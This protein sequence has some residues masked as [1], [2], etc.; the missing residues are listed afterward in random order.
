MVSLF[1]LRL[2]Q[3]STAVAQQ[4]Q[5][6]MHDAVGCMQR[7]TPDMFSNTIRGANIRAAHLLL[8]SWITA[9][10]SCRGAQQHSTAQHGR[11]QCRSHKSR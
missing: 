6:I 9:S 11:Q 1:E 3:V 7:R 5:P 10:V 4:A 8:R 2:K